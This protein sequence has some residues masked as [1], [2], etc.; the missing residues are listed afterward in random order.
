MI[1]EEEGEKSGSKG[2]KG[3]VDEG[4]ASKCFR[5]PFQSKKERDLWMERVMAAGWVK[6]KK[7]KKLRED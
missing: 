5:L 6:K 2:G 3:E 1:V 4:L 7:K